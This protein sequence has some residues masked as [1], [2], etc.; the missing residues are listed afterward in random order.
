MF[1]WVGLGGVGGGGIVGEEVVFEK[2]AYQ[3][4]EGSVVQADNALVVV[5]GVAVVPG[6]QVF[7]FEEDTT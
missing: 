4:P 1:S 5:G 2:E 3:E 7:L 6:A